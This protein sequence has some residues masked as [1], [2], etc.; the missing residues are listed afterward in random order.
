MRVW[1]KRTLPHHS[2]TLFLLFPSLVHFCG[3]LSFF[4]FFF[5][6]SSVFHRLQMLAWDFLSRTRK[7]KKGRKR[8]QR[9]IKWEDEQAW[10]ALPPYTLRRPLDTGVSTLQKTH[11]DRK[12]KEGEEQHCMYITAKSVYRCPPFFLYSLSSLSPYFLSWN[13]KSDG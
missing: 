13:A 5:F 12:K 7:R 2:V 8:R 6:E 3:S 4:S 9:K 1:E 10:G 11:T